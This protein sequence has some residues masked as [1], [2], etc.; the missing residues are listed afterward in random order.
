MLFL[1][2][3]LGIGEGVGFFG[4]DAEHICAAVLAELA[5]GGRLDAREARRKIGELGLEEETAF[6]LWS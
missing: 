2:Q 6:A 3:G 1:G 4:V 5:R